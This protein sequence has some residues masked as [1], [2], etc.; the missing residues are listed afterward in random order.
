MASARGAAELAA[1]QAHA[2]WESEVASSVASQIDVRK[3]AD[4]LIRADPDKYNAMVITAIN[5]GIAPKDILAAAFTS[6]KVEAEKARAATKVE[7]LPA[8][9][10]VGPMDPLLMTDAA[11][12]KGSAGYPTVAIPDMTQPPAPTN[13]ARGITR[14]PNAEQF[15]PGV[16]MGSPGAFPSGLGANAAMG[17]DNTYHPDF[18]GADANA[19]PEAPDT[20][21]GLDALTAM[22]GGMGQV[23][24]STRQS[25]QIASSGGE[26]PQPVAGPEAAFPPNPA[27][28]PVDPKGGYKRNDGYRNPDNNAA[29]LAYQTELQKLGFYKGPL[30]GKFGPLTQQAVHDYR[31]RNGLS[32]AK[33]VINTQMAER[34]RSGNQYGAT[35]PAPMKRQTDVQKGPI[36]PAE[37]A[38]APAPVPAPVPEPPPEPEVSQVPL[39]HQRPSDA[40]R[41]VASLGDTP[42]TPPPAPLPPGGAEEAYRSR[43][44]GSQ[45]PIPPTRPPTADEIVKSLNGKTPPKAPG[46]S[47]PAEASVP[48]K[49]PAEEN[50][51]IEGKPI[52]KGEEN[53]AKL[54]IQ[55]R[56]DVWDAVAARFDKDPEHKAIPYVDFDGN[57]QVM[58]AARR[59]ATS[60]P[61]SRPKAGG[62]SSIEGEGKGKG[63]QVASRPSND[64]VA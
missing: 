12:M 5:G 62:E 35:G 60:G 37:A 39:P 18:I 40:S 54:R 21:G 2:A 26:G 14:A 64:L 15:G 28:P 32:T 61:G 22:T 43:E 13:V 57:P 10:K 41:V 11:M 27:L 1:A 31:A 7:R 56:Q 6:Q 20:T 52:P 9:E 44:P 59:H 48:K 3:E 24:G 8:P 55:Q 23:A 49:V 36:P 38:P 63:K 29:I 30:D 46:E 34:M 51:P 45:V 25:P 17:T 47:A 33:P 16:A 19:R 42:A 50:K 53:T 4:A 58:D